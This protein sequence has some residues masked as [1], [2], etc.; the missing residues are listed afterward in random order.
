LKPTDAELAKV[1]E[2]LEADGYKI[3][4]KLKAAWIAEALRTAAQS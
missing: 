4:W 3:G 1:I 2:T